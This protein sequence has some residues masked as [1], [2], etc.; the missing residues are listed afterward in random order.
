[1][2]VRCARAEAARQDLQV[3]RPHPHRSSRRFLS[4]LL[5]FCVTSGVSSSVEGLL[6]VSRLPT[7]A[8]EALVLAKG[9]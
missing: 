9:L 2:R 6:I 4:S 1:M 7:F 8:Q 5:Y 3:N